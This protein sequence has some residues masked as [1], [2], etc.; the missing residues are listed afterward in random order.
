MFRSKTA[1]PILLILALVFVAFGDQFLPQPL[2]GASFRTRVAID[3]WMTGSFQFWHPKTDPYAR[4][5]RAIDRQETG[6]SP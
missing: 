2:S 4:T 1:I 3:H 6:K 5:E